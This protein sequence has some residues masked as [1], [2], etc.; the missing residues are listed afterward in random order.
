MHI[1]NMRLR[2]SSYQK[3]LNSTKNIEVRPLD[4]KRKNVQ[5]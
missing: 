5:L 4:E 3:I 2:D 1:H